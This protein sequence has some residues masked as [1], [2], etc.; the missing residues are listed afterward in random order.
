MADFTSGG[1]DWQPLYRFLKE[2]LSISVNVNMVEASTEFYTNLLA[3]LAD[4][5]VNVTSGQQQLNDAISKM[6]DTFGTVET[7]NR[8]GSIFFMDGFESGMGALNIANGGTGDSWVT[9]QIRK[10]GLQALAC[11]ASASGD[12]TSINK[13]LPFPSSNRI[14]IEISC[15]INNLFGNLSANIHFF[16][17][18]VQD[19][20][21]VR[22]SHDLAHTVSIT[23]GGASLT[24]LDYDLWLI[25][26]YG[27][28]T[29]KCVY[30]YIARQYVSLN[31][32]GHEYDLSAYSNQIGP[33][34]GQY[35]HVFCTMTAGASVTANSMSYIDD[36]I[37]TEEV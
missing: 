17:A 29:V 36:I 20:L 33:S 15:I 24:I 7:M 30:D 35:M 21:K 3:A 12:Y 26:S 28:F 6:V 14:G 19:T 1:P 4:L 25:P 5:S 34:T 8:L 31:F 11:K 13:I 32:M 22:I 18:G 27:W 23:N 37:I 9:R 10:S 16:G 2:A